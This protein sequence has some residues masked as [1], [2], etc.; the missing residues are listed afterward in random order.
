MIATTAIAHTMN[1]TITKQLPRDKLVEDAIKM[2][3][4][5]NSTGIAPKTAATPAQ[6]ATTLRIVFSFAF[7]ASHPS[8]LTCNSATSITSA[9]ML[10]AWPPTSAVGEILECPFSVAI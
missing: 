10:L 9:K 6:S 8:N 4:P 2:A 3:L 1:P 5:A 7:P